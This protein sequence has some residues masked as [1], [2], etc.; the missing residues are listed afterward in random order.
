MGYMTC[1]AECVGCAKTI[2]CNPSYVPTIRIKGEKEP[3]CAACVARMQ[4]RQK[5]AGVDVWPDPHPEAYEPEEC[6]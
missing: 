2:G 3:L 5:E 4:E 6:L 1:I